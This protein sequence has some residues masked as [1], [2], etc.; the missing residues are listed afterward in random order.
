MQ[1]IETDY[2]E[3]KYEQHSTVIIGR[4][5]VLNLVSNIKWPAKQ[6]NF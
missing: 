1:K 3:S 6:H 2:H 5:L 4:F